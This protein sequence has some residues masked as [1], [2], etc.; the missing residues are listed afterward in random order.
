[1]KKPS[2][3]K[4]RTDRRI[5]SSES[6]LFRKVVTKR[7]FLRETAYV[8]HL[9]LHKTL[10]NAFVLLV[11]GE[12]LRL[13]SPPRKR[14]T[15]EH[16]MQHSWSLFFI[17]GGRGS[18]E[19]G[20]KQSMAL[21]PGDIYLLPPFTRGHMR[22]RKGEK[23]TNIY[24]CVYDAKIVGDMCSSLALP[25]AGVLRLPEKD[26]AME[27]F[28]ERVR[29]CI[30]SATPENRAEENL[31]FL[32]YELFHHLLRH[33]IRSDGAREGFARLLQ[34][35]SAAPMGPYTLESM[36]KELGKS[37][38]TV[39]RLFREHTG[40]PPMKYLAGLRLDHAAKLL[41]EGD[42]GFTLEDTARICNYKSTGAF[43]AAFRKRFGTP[44]GAWKNAARRT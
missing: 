14:R 24:L 40:T 11:Y 27:V 30:L 6:C 8:D 13:P 2:F 17:T 21:A 22:V 28:L 4:P 37:P 12:T 41:R 26:H 39:Q 9:R 36:A 33:A 25:A 5:R 44:P 19:Y 7:K 23:L 1:M 42:G 34:T 35:L 15:K 29:A 10:L 38:R 3:E 43:A 16:V 32:C 31:S 20:N 18:V